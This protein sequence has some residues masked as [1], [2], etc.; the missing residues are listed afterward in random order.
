MYFICLVVFVYNNFRSSSTSER[1]CP[2]QC[3]QSFLTYALVQYREKHKCVVQIQ[4]RAVLSKF[5]LTRTGSSAQEREVNCLNKCARNNFRS[6]NVC[7]RESE[8]V[9]GLCPP[10]FQRTALRS[11]VKNKKNRSQNKREKLFII[12]CY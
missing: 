5:Y 4:T 1:F 7:V 8:C 10:K 2:R 9:C 12:I 11:A 3:C 6:I